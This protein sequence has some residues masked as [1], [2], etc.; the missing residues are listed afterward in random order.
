MTHPSRARSGRIPVGWRAGSAA[1]GLTLL[2]GCSSQPPAQRSV[3][4][5]SPSSPRPLALVGGTIVDVAGGG[6]STA[7]VRDAVVVIRGGTIV[8]AGPRATTPVPASARVID[9]AGTFVVPGLNDVFAGL[10]SQA[11]ANAYL[12]KGVTSILGSDEPGGRRGALLLTAQ[13]SPRIRKL[14]MVYGLERTDEAV[15][16][17]T[18]EEILRGLETDVANGV[19]ALLLYYTL[20][21]EQVALATRRAHELGVSTIGELGRTTYTQGI[22]AGI[23]AVVHTSRYSLELADPETRAAVAAN[24]FGPPRTAFYEYLA[25]LDPDSPVVTSWAQR[26]AAS[27][28]AHI[29]TLSLSYYDLP[30]HDNPWTDP[31]A[32][33]LDPAGIHLPVDRESGKRERPPGIAAGLPASLLRIEERYRRAGAPY[34]AGSG[35]S[36]FGTLPGIALHL[37]LR[38]LVQIGLTPRQ[39]LAAATSNVGEVF[40]WSRVGRVAAGYDGDLVVVDADP[41]VDIRN[42]EKIRMVVLA[43]EIVDRPALLK[44]PSS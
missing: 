3:G 28:V 44:I 39:A 33:I 40:R 14:G 36:A 10:N 5:G 12:Y 17:Q 41:T 25:G 26:L 13:P 19:G 15:V 21:P 35:T 31:I 11:Q 37:E 30:E 22:E 29:P 6:G 8:A 2:L 34:V 18:N 9:I 7:D 4:G 20:E 27:R 16:P 32:A 42:L 43:G 38:L 24:P 23:D 1:V